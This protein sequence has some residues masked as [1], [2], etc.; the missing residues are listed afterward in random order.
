MQRQFRRRT[1]AAVRLAKGICIGHRIHNT[2]RFDIRRSIPTASCVFIACRRD[3]NGGHR[4][5]GQCAAD[6]AVCLGIQHNGN[7]SVLGCSAGPIAVYNFKRDGGIFCPAG[8]NGLCSIKC[9]GV[10]I[11]DLPCILIIIPAEEGISLFHRRTQRIDMVVCICRYRNI[12]DLRLTLGKLPHSAVGVK[13]NDRPPLGNEVP[14]T[15]HRHRLNLAAGVGDIRIGIFFLPSLEIVCGSAIGSRR[16]DCFIKI[17][18]IGNGI[19]DG[20]GTIVEIS[21]GQLLVIICIKSYS[22][23]RVAPFAV[24]RQ[25]FHIRIF[26][27]IFGA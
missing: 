1:A 27:R 13:G 4:A 7:I 19:A 20:I 26:K 12:S 8:I 14:V 9:L 24:E 11:N 16:R 2:V 22:A 6:G 25:V 3:H 5:C 18:T 17:R 10:E 23:V 21:T 15:L